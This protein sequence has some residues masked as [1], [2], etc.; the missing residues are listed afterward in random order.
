MRK[1]VLHLLNTSSYSGAEKIAIFIIN[2]TSESVESGYC[3]LSGK[4]SEKLSANKINYYPIS[5]MSVREVKRVIKEFNPDFIHAHDFTSSVIA[6]LTLTSVPIISHLHNNAP[7]IKT[8]H[9]YSLIYLICTSRFKS[10]LTVSQAIIKE[11]IFGRVILRKSYVVSNPIASQDR[12]IKHKMN[13]ILDYDLIFVGRLVKEK[14]PLKLLSVVNIVKSKY[15]EVK[16]L[17]VGEGILYEECM[18]TIKKLKLENNVQM[19][20]FVDKPEEYIYSSK[21]LCMTST[22]EGFGLVASEALSLGVPVIATP[23]GGIPEILDEDSGFLTNDDE[24]YA[25]E[26]I[27]LICDHDYW[28]LKSTHALRRSKEIENKDEYVAKILLQY[29]IY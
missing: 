17:I 14:N 10:I 8:L 5:S 27:R 3:S 26:I 11:Y 12:F 13:R 22:Y 4:I 24:E 6:G 23:V 15:P 16:A 20:G 18:E 7:W 9:P 28:T 1:R 29:E 21:V 2:S 19:I 25:T